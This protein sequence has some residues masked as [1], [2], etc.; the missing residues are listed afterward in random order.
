MVN[1]YSLHVQIEVEMAPK[2]DGSSKTQSKSSKKKNGSDKKEK[3]VKQLAKAI[4]KEQKAKDKEVAKASKR[5]KKQ[6]QTTAAAADQAKTTRNKDWSTSEMRLVVDE[7][8]A[9]YAKLFANVTETFRMK[10]KAKIWEGIATK[11]SA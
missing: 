9:N 2:G 8:F 1:K 6:S 4:V 3:T 7:V 5:S 11:V 10:D